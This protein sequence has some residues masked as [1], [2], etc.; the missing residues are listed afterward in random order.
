M[1]V[2]T[3]SPMP[4]TAP[5]FAKMVTYHFLKYLRKPLSTPGGMM[6]G[7]SDWSSFTPNGLPVPP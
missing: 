5:R 1:K 4:N 3:V 6:A 7:L 2:V